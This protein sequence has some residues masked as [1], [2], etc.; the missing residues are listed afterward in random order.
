MAAARRIQST[1]L[2]A[3]T[4]VSR[5]I[6]T[7]VLGASIAAGSHPLMSQD[8]FRR[9]LRHQEIRTVF[10]LLRQTYFFL[11]Q[12]HVCASSS[13]NKD[14]TASASESELIKAQKGSSTEALSLGCVIK[15]GAS[16]AA[17]SHPLISQNLLWPF[18]RQEVRSFCT[19]PDDPQKEKSMKEVLQFAK[20]ILEVFST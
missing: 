2:A 13:S 20:K 8:L 6:Q 15:K 14:I 1:A 11:Q 17:G 3:S 10:G 18:P 19:F 16:T 4:A 12:R 9:R 5:R 7:T